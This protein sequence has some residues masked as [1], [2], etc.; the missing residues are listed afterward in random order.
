[1][2]NS[3]YKNTRYFNNNYSIY[4]NVLEERGVKFVRQYATTS[5]KHLT[6]AQ[7]GSLVEKQIS[8]EYGDRL[9][10]VASREYNDASYWW[11][12]ARYNNKPTDAHF[13][14]GDIIL[15]PHP[16]NLILGYYTE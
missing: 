16:L 3:R 9:D 14:R 4:E 11:I 6:T 10:K 13:E 5:F 7:K 8:W 12:I 1:M 15:V 2:A